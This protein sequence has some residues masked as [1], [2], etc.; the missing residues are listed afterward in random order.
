MLR[1]PLSLSRLSRLF[2]CAALLS[3]AGAAAAG[4]TYPV[5]REATRGRWAIWD[6]QTASAFRRGA[7]WPVADGGPIPGLDP[8]YAFLLQVLIEPPTIDS[9][10]QEIAYPCPE[11]ADLTAATL[12]TTCTATVRDPAALRSAAENAAQARISEAMGL[13]GLRDPADQVRAIGLLLQ[14][15]QGVVL[16]VAQ[17][18]WLAGLGVAG[19]EYIDQVRAKQAEIDA[20][21]TAHPG[22]IPDL[23]AS[24]WPP[25]PRA[26]E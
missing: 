11:V 14:A 18:A 20:W 4:I 5:D 23:G 10:L 17:E 15:R 16:N 25:L 21:I 2:L 22:Q 19:V 8:R 9:R 1:F 7:D 13:L 3:G 26:P 12:T 24:V 6:L